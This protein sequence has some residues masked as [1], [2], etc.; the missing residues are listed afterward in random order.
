MTDPLDIGIDDD[1][2]LPLDDD[3]GEIDDCLWDFREVLPAWSEWTG[4][5]AHCRWIAARLDEWAGRA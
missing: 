2:S 1:L 3:G 5:A 4:T